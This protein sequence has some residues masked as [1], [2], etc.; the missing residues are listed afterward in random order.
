MGAYLT[1]R[2]AS[3]A[4]TLIGI[5][6]A[7][8]LLIHAAP[9]DPVILYAGLRPGEPVP[10]AVLD[11]I[12]AEHGLDRPLPEQYVRWIAG[13]VRLDLRDSIRF[14][15][16]VVRV[17]GDHL[18]QTLLLAGVALAVALAVSLPLG[19]ATAVRAGSQFDRV[20]GALLFLLYSLPSF[21][22]ALLA[23]EIFGVRLGLLPLFGMSSPQADT[24]GVGGRFVDRVLHLVLPVTVLAYGLVALFARFVRSALLETL[25]EEYITTARAKGASAGAVLWKHA[26]RNSMIS[27]LSVLGLVVPWLVSG[28]IIVE[29]IFQWNGIGRLFFSAILSRDYPLVM[30]LTLLTA[31]VT[32]VSSLVADLCIAAAD[33][34]V[35]LGGDAR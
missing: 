10:R 1:R 2:I 7:V 12:R 14:R 25:R 4:V 21:W 13:A 11:A 8:F 20:T 3:A 24:M 31:V 6:T 17:I 32:L 18:P 22:I 23:I 16:P 19:A 28:S 35:R 33:P 26:W 34:R 5:L 30:G 29:Q 9:G 15:R 27:L